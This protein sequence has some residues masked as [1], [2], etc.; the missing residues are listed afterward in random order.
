MCRQDLEVCCELRAFSDR[1]STLSI[2]LPDITQC[3]APPHPSNSARPNSC[4]KFIGTGNTVAVADA[5]LGAA[6]HD[7]DEKAAT[8]QEHAPD[9]LVDPTEATTAEKSR[10]FPYSDGIY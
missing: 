4:I 2:T 6:A 7:D 9:A 8:E 1:K 5:S 10:E 3:T